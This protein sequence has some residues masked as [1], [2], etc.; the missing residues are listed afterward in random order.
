VFS[1]SCIQACRASGRHI[2]AFEEDVDIF[3]ALIAPQMLKTVVNVSEPP[4]LAPDSFD[5][6]EEDVE[7]EII[8]ASNRFSSK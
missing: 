1:G 5:L 2:L 6:E 3:N 7:P 8:V 4:P